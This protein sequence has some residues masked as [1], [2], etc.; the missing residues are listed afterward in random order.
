VFISS[1]N[2]LDRVTKEMQQG[3]TNIYSKLE[4]RMLVD[5]REIKE[6]RKKNNLEHLQDIDIKDMKRT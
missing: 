5:I 4:R 6:S 3:K 2:Y 1:K